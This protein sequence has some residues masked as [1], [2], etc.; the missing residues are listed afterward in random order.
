MSKEFN[1]AMKC[2]E[3]LLEQHT[4]RLLDANKEDIKEECDAGWHDLE[5]LVDCIKANLE[6]KWKGVE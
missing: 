6:V 4:L 1:S 2:L 5:D 3:I